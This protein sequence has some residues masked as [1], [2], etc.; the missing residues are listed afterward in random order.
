LIIAHLLT[1]P[2]EITVVG[3]QRLSVSVGDACFAVWTV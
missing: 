1:L 2:E 3:A